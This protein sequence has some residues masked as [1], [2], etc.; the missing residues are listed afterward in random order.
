[1]QFYVLRLRVR[2]ILKVLSGGNIRGWLENFVRRWVSVSRLYCI[3]ASES[4]VDEEMCYNKK[5]EVS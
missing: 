3:Y 2:A 4:S 1:M 5:W